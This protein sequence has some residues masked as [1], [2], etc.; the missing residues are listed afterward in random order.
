MEVRVGGGFEELPLLRAVT[1][2]VA[3]LGDFTLDE[4]SDVTL[5]VDEVCSVLIRDALPGA[6]LVCRLTPTVGALRV[7]VSTD[8][9][10][11]HHPDERTF[12]WHVLRTLT[13]NLS[14]H[15]YPLDPNGFRTDVG[16]VKTGDGGGPPT[17]LI[18]PSG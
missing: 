16:F 10:T 13:D 12:G 3:L 9:A 14:A 11:D 2:A 18:T 8:T 6:E 5:A 15:R 7:G 1:E 17:P 4:V